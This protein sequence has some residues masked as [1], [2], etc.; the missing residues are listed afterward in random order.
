VKWVLVRPLHR[1]R[2]SAGLAA[3]LL[4]TPAAPI[5]ETV[6]VLDPVIYAVSQLII[7]T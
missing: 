7:A 2:F 5:G 1:R 6:H 3:L 4:A